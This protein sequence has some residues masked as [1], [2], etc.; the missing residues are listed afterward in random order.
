[1]VSNLT[2]GKPEYRENWDEMEEVGIKGQHLKEWFLSAIDRDTDAF[3]SL[4]D[5]MR[6]PAKTQEQKEERKK[7]LQSANIHATNVP[8]EVLEKTL[9]VTPLLLAVAERGNPN[10]VSDAGVGAHCLL[11]CAEAAALNVR[12]N[13]PGIKDKKLVDDCHNRVENS[14]G[15]I[16]KLVKEVVDVVDGILKEQ[17]KG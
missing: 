4:M 10:S 13:L 17:A 12:I 7:A 9:E 3:N 14:M 6:M 5:A 16:K 15:E 8:L 2:H 11:A 1:M